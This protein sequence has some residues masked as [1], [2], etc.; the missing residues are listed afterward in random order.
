MAI[1]REAYL[2]VKEVAERLRLHPITVRRLIASGRLPAVRIG[3]AVRVRE[4]DVGSVGT[5]DVPA[6]G[7]PYR[8]PPTKEELERRR[9]VIDEMLA[10]RDSMPPLGIST[11]ELLRESRRELEER[12]ERRAQGRS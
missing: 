4:G 8:W 6:R 5:R 3:R 2:T 1:D 9:K 12:D 11:T 7:L 10:Y